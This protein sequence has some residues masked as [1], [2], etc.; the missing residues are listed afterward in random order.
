MK[1]L[2]IY[3]FFMYIGIYL[4]L[5]YKFSIHFSINECINALRQ[6]HAYCQ[7]NGELIF[8]TYSARSV[9]FVWQVRP[10]S[11]GFELIFSVNTANVLTTTPS[12][13]SSR[14]QV[15]IYF[16]LY[17]VKYYTSGEFRQNASCVVNTGTPCW[18]SK[19]FAT[20][21]RPPSVGN[22]KSI[23]LRIVEMSVCPQL[24]GCLRF[25][26]MFN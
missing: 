22:R 2:R 11:K 12:Y 16:T 26:I 14:L 8:K 1:L 10:T 19:R 18:L 20:E 13:H 17:F 6:T 15:K 5:K 21:F 23:G 24:E 9:F 3:C 7:H 4:Y 25:V